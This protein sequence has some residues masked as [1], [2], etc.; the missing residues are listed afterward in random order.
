MFLSI[1]FL[2]RIKKLIFKK[3][4]KNGKDLGYDNSIEREGIEK[5]VGLKLIKSGWLNQ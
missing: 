2:N 5:G 4:T 3:K 1:V